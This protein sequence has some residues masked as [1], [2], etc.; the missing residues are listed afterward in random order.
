MKWNCRGVQCTLKDSNLILLSIE[1][2]WKWIYKKKLRLSKKMKWLAPYTWFKICLIH[3]CSRCRTL[4]WFAKIIFKCLNIFISDSE[5]CFW[6]LSSEQS[7]KTSEVKRW[8]KEFWQIWK[9]EETH[10]PEENMKLIIIISK[11]ERVII[12]TDLYQR[13]VS[14]KTV[15][16]TVVWLHLELIIYWFLFCYIL[17]I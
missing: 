14:K 10:V 17:N 5:R 4:T 2:T 11:Q 15:E 12:C 1:C 7:S 16:F 8:K 3:K 13:R 9:L 6:V